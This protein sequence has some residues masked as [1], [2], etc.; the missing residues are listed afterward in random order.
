MVTISLTRSVPGQNRQDM[1]K[2]YYVPLAIF[3]KNDATSTKVL[4]AT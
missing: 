2:V 3:I 4:R 1:T